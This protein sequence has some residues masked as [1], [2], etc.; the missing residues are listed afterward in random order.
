MYD[1]NDTMRQ[2]QGRIS[3]VLDHVGFLSPAMRRPVNKTT[4]PA[5]WQVNLQQMARRGTDF[6][7]M[8]NE[9]IY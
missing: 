1:G 5:M 9:V 6:E 4:L 3:H 7:N 8:L 2:H